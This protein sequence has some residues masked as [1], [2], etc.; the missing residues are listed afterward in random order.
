MVRKTGLASR[1]IDEEQKRKRAKKIERIEHSEW[2]LNSDDKLFPRS[3]QID[4]TLRIEETK[5]LPL[6]LSHIYG[7]KVGQEDKFDDYLKQTQQRENPFSASIIVQTG[8]DN[9]CTFCIVPYTRGQEISRSHS[10]I[11]QECRDAVSSGAKEITLLW[12]NVNSYGK[13]FMSK[14]LWNEEK[15][16]WN[17]EEKQNLKIGIDLDDTLFEVWCPSVLEIYNRKYKEILAFDEIVTFDFNGIKELRHEYRSYATKNKFSLQLQNWAE[18]TLKKLK[19]EGNQLY[20]ITSRLP[21][22]RN[23]TEKVLEE[24]FWKDFFSWIY[25]TLEEWVDTKYTIAEKLK[26]DIVIDDAP[27]HIHA[28]NENTSIKTLVYSQTWNKDIKTQANILERVTNWN[29]I[30]N[31]VQN[32]SFQSPFS[33]LLQDINTIPKLERIRFTSS[34]PHDMTKDILDSHFT[35]DKSC[36]YLH[37]ALQSWNNTMLKK[38]NRRHTYEDF[39][40]MVTYLRSK[41]PLFSISTDIIVG[42]S[43]ETDEMFQ[44]TVT[45]FKEC[46]FDFAYIARYSVRPQ[47]IASKI[48]PDDIPDEIKAERWHTLNDLLLENIQKR[49]TLMIGNTQDIIISGE[50]DEFMFGRTRNF[51]EV[52]I[53]KDSRISIWDTVSTKITGMDRYVLQWKIV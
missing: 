42:Y 30:L 21:E 25:F 19:E 5:F 10:E 50:K 48:Y 6:L 36:N 24:L 9:Y 34:N 7:E 23:D 28:Y 51:K 37:F 31:V 20:I 1:Y 2:I 29:E 18:K 38:M 45:A 49:N 44:D 22:E 8:C 17:T 52:F 27:H 13:Q 35:L 41:D 43:W 46:V 14:K 15:S 33:L 47:T 40:K 4:F 3:E 32:H 39:K 12:Q 53:E 16:K 11:L 26:L